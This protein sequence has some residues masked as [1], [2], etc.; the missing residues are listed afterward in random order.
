MHV[1]VEPDTN[2]LCAIQY[3]EKY[4]P[5]W[6]QTINGFAPISYPEG[7]LLCLEPCGLCFVPSIVFK[8][9]R[10]VCGNARI[11]LGAC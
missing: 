2:C 6:N 4:I 1:C 7:K 11:I 3:P 10:C 5:V 9:I 8:V